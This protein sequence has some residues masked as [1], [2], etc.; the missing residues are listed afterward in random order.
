M[1]IAIKMFVQHLLS[2]LE[3]SLMAGIKK[4]IKQDLEIL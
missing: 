3:K 1:N 4:I 2:Y